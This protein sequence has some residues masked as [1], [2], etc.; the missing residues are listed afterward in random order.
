MLQAKE[1][2]GNGFVFLVGMRK[3]KYRRS[4]DCYSV[5]VLS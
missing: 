5:K 2:P 4:D 1:S 3:W